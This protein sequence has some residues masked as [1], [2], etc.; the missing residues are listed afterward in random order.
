[1]K[2]SANYAVDFESQFDSFDMI[3]QWN[4]EILKII[5]SFAWLQ[6]LSK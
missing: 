5:E 2:L 4:T 6:E 1:M 3:L